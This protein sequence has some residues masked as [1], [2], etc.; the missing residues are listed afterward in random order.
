MPSCALPESLNGVVRP[1]RPR[2]RQPL[3]KPRHARRV[4]LAALTRSAQYPDGSAAHGY[5]I[6]APLDPTGHLDAT[7]WRKQRDH[8][9][10]IG[11][12]SPSAMAGSYTAPVARKARG[13]LL[14]TMTGRRG[15]SNGLPLAVAQVPV[16]RGFCP[17]CGS[18]V[19]VKLARRPDLIGV[20]PAL[21]DP[22]SFRPA[23]DVFTVRAQPWDTMPPDTRKFQAEFVPQR[24]S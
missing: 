1:T 20:Y 24:P 19:F 9:H 5:D 6:V 16:E 14:I 3:Q 21:D 7:G 18:P 2:P 8:C 11:T 17:R 10:G 12:V 15:R 13:G 4:P 22:S 23:M